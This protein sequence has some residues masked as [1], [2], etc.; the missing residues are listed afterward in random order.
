MGLKLDHEVQYCCKHGTELRHPA[1]AADS[2][3]NTGKQS[4][5]A[6]IADYHLA[7]DHDRR[8]AVVVQ[9]SVH[10]DYMDDNCAGN[11]HRSDSKGKDFR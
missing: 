7:V 8:N 10:N 11:Q 1:E 3:D 2:R 9:K 5:E 4:A 6:Q